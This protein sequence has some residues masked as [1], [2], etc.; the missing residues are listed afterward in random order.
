MEQPGHLSRVFA[1]VKA[2]ASHQWG[3]QFIPGLSLMCG[4]SVMVL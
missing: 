3:L 1:V 2:I 4:L